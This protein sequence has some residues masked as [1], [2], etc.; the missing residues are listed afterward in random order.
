M[1]VGSVDV[2]TQTGTSNQ[3]YVIDENT[4]MPAV[5]EAG[6]RV[7]VDFDTSTLVAHSVTVI[8][9]SG[10]GERES[11][12][13]TV[14]AISSV[15]ITIEA[16]T[17]DRM[18][19]LTLI[20]DEDTSMRETP[21]V[22]DTVR[23]RYNTATN[24]AIKIRVITDHGGSHYDRIEGFVTAISDT[25]ITIE[26]MDDG[27]AATRTTGVTET[28]AI[29]ENTWIPQSVEVGDEVRIVV[30]VES[31]IVMSIHLLDGGE[32]PIHAYDKVRGTVTAV[33][34]LSITIE[35]DDNDRMSTLTFTIDDDTWVDGEPEIDDRVRIEY[36]TETRVALSI[37]V[38]GDNG[39][40]GWPGYNDFVEITGTLEAISDTA[41]TVDGVEYQVNHHTYIEGTPAV[42]D[43]VYIYAEIDEDT[44]I[45]HYIAIYDDD[46]GGGEEFEFDWAGMVTEI[47][48]DSITVRNV[49]FGMANED[50]FIINA[51]TV[52]EGEV[53]AG[54]FVEIHALYHSDD[55]MTALHIEKI[56]DSEPTI[57][58][59][60]GVVT[61]IITDSLTIDVE[62]SERTLH[63]FILTDDTHFSDRPEVG[64]YVR[65]KAERDTDDVLTAL[66]VRVD[67]PE[68]VF[69]TV[70]GTVTAVMSDS[71]TVDDGMTTTVRAL[72]TFAIDENTMMRETPVVGDRVRVK[73]TEINGVLTA[74]E[75]RIRETNPEPIEYVEAIGT[76]EMTTTIDYVVDGITYTVSAESVV[77]GN[78]QIGDTVYVLAMV[79]DDGLIIKY[80]A[81]FDQPAER[82]E[83]EGN[84]DAFDDDTIT[85]DG[86]VISL[87]TDTTIRGT[88]T[89]DADVFVKGRVE[90]GAMVAYRVRVR[91]DNSQERFVEALGEISASSAT[92]ITVDGTTFILDD[93]TEIEGTPA[94][95]LKAYVFGVN[96]DG[97]VTALFVHVVDEQNQEGVIEDLSVNGITING[98]TI[99]I[100]NRTRI[101][102]NFSVG[103]KVYVG[104]EGGARAA[105]GDALYI[106]RATSAPTAVTLSGSTTIVN[107]VLGLLAL[108]FTTLTLS[109]L[110]FARRKFNL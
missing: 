93:D 3:T 100:N 106:G 99:R 97:T 71:I 66:W 24:V 91:G 48:S 42:N 96:D 21:E 16:E 80:L 55:S 74:I 92:E 39:W 23:A 47:L 52:I 53:V 84:L 64:D 22:G 44:F 75:I 90:D 19:T 73:G 15:S 60:E 30:D 8:G 29:D 34:P 102:G 62:D 50:T 103:D 1:L 67:E 43:V 14:T 33:T 32:P 31:G 108:L 57:E 89:I 27:E 88:L 54:D 5:P 59:Y 49:W 35:L 70:R 45:A 11:I 26:V 37:R 83:L 7:R 105:A 65:V 58:R 94:I 10:S 69:T 104:M 63:T 86:Q 4:W 18:S 36:N 109:T 6:D 41:Y 38:V 40:P 68:P 28:F 72:T 101:D 20:I 78:P 77:E 98:Q 25:S 82:F 79:G 17:D 76:L 56:D 87:T 110:W 51:E 81:K 107:G 12:R 46:L 9:G 2:E 85:V 13:G 95:G 61:E